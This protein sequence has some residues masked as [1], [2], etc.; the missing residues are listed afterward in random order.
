M[1]RRGPAPDPPHLKALRAPA[2]SKRDKRGK[3][4]LNDAQPAIADVAKPPEYLKGNA[5]WFWQ[6]LAPEAARV[7]FLTVLSVHS[8]AAACEAFS[9]WRQYEG[10]CAEVGPQPA[11]MMGYRNAADRARDALVKVGARF[12]LDPTALANVKASPPKDPSD[13]AEEKRRRFFGVSGGRQA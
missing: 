13:E 7:G 10:L 8:F 9:T 12:G 1:G 11:V 4:Q 6:Q 3:E 2:R 5:L